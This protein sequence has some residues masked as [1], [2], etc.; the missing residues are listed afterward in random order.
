MSLGPTEMTKARNHL[1]TINPDILWDCVQQY[2]S[3]TMAKLCRIAHPAPWVRG[4]IRNGWMATDGIL[5][6]IA[7]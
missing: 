3:S 4:R 2:S 6:G 5:L 7:M 1:V